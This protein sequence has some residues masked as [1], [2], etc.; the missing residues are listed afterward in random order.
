MAPRSGPFS[1]APAL[2]AGATF[3]LQVARK[4]CY[5]RQIE[6]QKLGG[7]TMCRTCDS[8]MIGRRSFLAGLAVGGLVLASGQSFAA[9]GPTTSMTA[10]PAL[11]AL[12]SGND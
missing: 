7:P 4:L 5:G 11:A 12:K 9:G 10:D 1:Y 6:S 2:D 3:W 8:R